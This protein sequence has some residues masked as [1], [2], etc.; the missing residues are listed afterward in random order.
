MNKSEQA[1]AIAKIRERT[2]NNSQVYSVILMLRSIPKE[3]LETHNE[4]V[5]LLEI[6][7]SQAQKIAELTALCETPN[8]IMQNAARKMV[9]LESQLLEARKEAHLYRTNFCMAARAATDDWL[10]PWEIKP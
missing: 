8:A 7:D 10:L 5:T 3:T 4:F 1:Q 6:V 9:E 2:K